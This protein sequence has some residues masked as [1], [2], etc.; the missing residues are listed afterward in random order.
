VAAWKDEKRT[1]EKMT[2]W[3]AA[4]LNYVR[5]SQLAAEVTRKCLKTTAAKESEKRTGG[6]LKMVKWENGKPVKAAA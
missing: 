2:F 4:G 5:Y 1:T 3:R 6:T